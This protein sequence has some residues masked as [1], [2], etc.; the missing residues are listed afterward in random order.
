MYV[1][2]G[3]PLPTA[4]GVDAVV[5]STGA[6][7]SYTAESGAN[8]VARQIGLALDGGDEGA[9][10]LS[11]GAGGVRLTNDAISAFLAAPDAPGG[12][13]ALGLRDLPVFIS[14][15]PYA[16]N[17]A[18]LAAN[19]L[20]RFDPSP[21][22]LAGRTLVMN[23]IAVGSVVSGVNA[24]VILRDVTNNADAATL[25]YT[26]T[27]ITPKSAGVTVPGGPTTYE[28]RSVVNS[29]VG[30]VAFGA[31]LRLTWS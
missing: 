5:R 11:D 23:F 6:G 7:T 16:T 21:Y 4:A 10:I 8:Y 24:S 29:G 25:T 14:L 20:F 26:E 28:L 2:A 12:R 27:A 17:D 1:T 13:T 15:S 9:T 3:T 30:Y 22:G 31:V 19:G 18:G